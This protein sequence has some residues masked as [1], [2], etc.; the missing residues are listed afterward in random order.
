MKRSI[1]HW[2]HASEV[3]LEIKIWDYLNMC[4]ISSHWP[5]G[6]NILK[7]KADCQNGGPLIF[8]IYRSGGGGESRD[9]GKETC[10]KSPS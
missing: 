2:V 10:H 7:E 8:I 6:E 1:R 9:V 3:W 4:G 5:K